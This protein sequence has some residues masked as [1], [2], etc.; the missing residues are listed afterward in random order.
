MT[1]AK[2]QQETDGTTVTGE[3]SLARMVATASLTLNPYQPRSEASSEG[4]A[5]LAA[6]IRSSGMIQPISVRIVDGKLQIIAGERRWRAATLAG[7][8]QVPVIVREADDRQMLELAL[9]ENIQREDLN[10]IDRARAYGVYCDRFELTVDQVA[11]RLG[12]DRSTVANY[13]RLLD[14]EDDICAMLADGRLSMGHARCIVGVADAATRMRLAQ[15][16]VVNQLSVRALEEI[17][18]REKK[19]LA[20]KGDGE[21]R[22]V[23]SAHVRELEHCLGVATGTK[24]TVQLSK[25]KGSGR[26]I[27]EF[28]SLDDF[29]R[30]SGLLGMP[31]SE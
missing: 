7:M 4:V 21:G 15:A 26:M 22:P 25:K 23:K 2:A 27:I 10:P 24:V 12:E 5:S 17:I 30:I 13:L 20:R 28:Y 19:G 3:A 9:V 29:D 31:P 1:P 18:R 11:E 8:D 6:S 14:L 16:A